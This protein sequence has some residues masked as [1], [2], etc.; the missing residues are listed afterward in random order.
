MPAKHT[1]Q[2]AMKSQRGSI[3][4]PYAIS[5][6]ERN[7]SESASSRKA[8]TTLNEV[9][10]SPDLG[11]C[12]IHSGNMAKSEN[13]RARAMAKPSIPTAGASKDLP[14]ASTSSVPMMGPV[15]EN[16]TMTSVK[17]MSNMLRKPPVERALLSSAVDHESGSVIS[18]RPKNDKAKTTSSRKKKIF[19]IALVLRSLSA[20][21]PKS[22]VTKSPRPT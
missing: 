18:N 3:P 17:A 16:E 15:Q 7:L 21:A 22:S 10:Q 19:T 8:R 20:E 5:A 2:I 1:I 12:F 11:A 13:G 14:A 6:T 4:H 9:I